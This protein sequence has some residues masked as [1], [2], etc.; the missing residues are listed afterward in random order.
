MSILIN[1]FYPIQILHRLLHYHLN[2]M[3]SEVYLL[4]I[5]GPLL[6]QN[7]EIN[8]TSTNCQS[9]TLFIVLYI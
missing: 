2:I 4:L 9:L 5:I 3:V 1:L 8:R 7:A 6:S